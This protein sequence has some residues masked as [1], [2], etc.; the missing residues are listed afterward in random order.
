MAATTPKGKKELAIGVTQDRL[1]ALGGGDKAVG[2]RISEAQSK[3]KVAM[4]KLKQAVKESSE[5][6]KPPAKKAVEVASEV[7]D[8]D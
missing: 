3:Q 8:V 5:P 6:P 4:K 2:E 1:L 7:V